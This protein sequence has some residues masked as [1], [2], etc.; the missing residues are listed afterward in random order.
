MDAQQRRAE[1][2]GDVA[3][4]DVQVRLGEAAIAHTV[5]RTEGQCRIRFAADVTIQ[6]GQTLSVRL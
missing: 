6:S 1:Q 2:F 3:V 4:K 5:E